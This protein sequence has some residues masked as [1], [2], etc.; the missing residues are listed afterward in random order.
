MAGD[1][2][3]SPLQGEDDCLWLEIL[4]Y[5]KGEMTDHIRRSL[6]H[7]YKGEMTGHGCR[8]LFH[9]YKA[10]MTDRG[11]RFLQI[12]LLPLRWRDD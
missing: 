4:H 8:Y 11:L 2:S 6:F 3:L 7:H 1:L 9:D 12:S 5:Y 10:E